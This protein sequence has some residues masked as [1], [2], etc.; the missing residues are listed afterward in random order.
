MIYNWD[1]YSFNTKNM[2]SLSMEY[3]GFG[4]KYK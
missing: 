2:F 4:N 3:L 1:T